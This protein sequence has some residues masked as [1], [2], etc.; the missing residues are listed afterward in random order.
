MKDRRRLGSLFRMVGVTLTLSM[1]SLWLAAPLP[2]SLPLSVAGLPGT[3]A[4]VLPSNYQGDA[5]IELAAGD[6]S[7]AIGALGT[8]VK[9]GYDQ[10]AMALEA[11]NVVV[12][13]KDSAWVLRL[14]D[15]GVVTLPEMGEE[16]YL[17]QSTVYRDVPFIAVVGGG[18]LGQAYGMFRLAEKVRL[19]PDSLEGELN[20]RSE[21]AMTLRLVSSPGFDNYPSPEDALRWG[22][23]AIMIGAWPGLALYDGFDPA[24][25]DR[26]LHAQDRDWVEANRARARVDIA[27]AKALHLK[28]VTMGD[29]FQLPRQALT[30]Y[31]AQVGAE[32]NP[33][34]FCIARPKTKALLAYGLREILS[35]FPDID[36]VMVRTGE[37]YPLGPLAGN[38]P[39]Q[40]NCGGLSYAQRIHE[41]IDVIYK[42][43]VEESGKI[44]I[45]RAWDLWNTGTHA[46]PDVMRD[47]LQDLQGKPGLILSFKQTQ[48]DFWRY[49]AVNPNIGDLAGQQMVEFQMA[50]EYEGK[51]AFPNYLGEMMA[52]GAPE[53]EPRGGMDYVYQKGVR[54]IWVWA[55][56]GG[57]GGPYP[58]S[59]LWIEPN[60][61]A[62]SHL[63]WD[64]SLSAEAMARDWASLRFGSAASPAIAKVLMESEDAILHT[65][66]IQA[67][68]K[69]FGPW[70]PH[71]L[72]LRD[73][74]IYGEPMISQIYQVL[75]SNDGLTSAMEEKRQAL[76]TVD[77]MIGGLEGVLDVASDQKLA[78]Q[79]LNTVRYE[80]SLSEVLGHYLSGMLYYFSW[81]DGGRKDVDAR[82][83]GRMELREWVRSWETYAT[84][85]ASL[86]GVASPYQDSGMGKA[87]LQALTEI[88]EAH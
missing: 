50:R 66:Y 18:V 12:G 34:L 52:L 36:A 58:T 2:K 13:D 74:V 22:F 57:W 10:D 4:L 29:V 72:W 85:V 3:V 68:A 79:A 84:Q 49:N 78:E 53:I 20:L 48:T 9:T 6:L 65:F 41:I 56:G 67:A 47:A 61:Y 26:K 81:K 51:G 24:I 27:A 30:L 14:V 87:G 19:E 16:G 59:D 55:K 42:Q 63:A 62:A 31:G 44:Y 35:D 82:E 77:S 37:N 86:E 5:A 75:K 25:F 28:V 21:P 46:S 11:V 76:Q 7:Q 23:N 64:P 54:A 15:A 8:S 70:T 17:V 45:H 73:D 71:D 32:D 43:V 88:E 83:R 69:S 39:A 1:L 38:S 40:G 60:I 33:G 80:R